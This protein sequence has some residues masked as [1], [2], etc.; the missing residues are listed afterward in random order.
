[1]AGFAYHDTVNTI[2]FT[3]TLCLNISHSLQLRNL[4]LN[5]VCCCCCL[6]RSVR[7]GDRGIFRAS[8]SRV[9]TG[10][11]QQSQLCEIN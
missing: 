9:R 10:I 1:M 11:I 2:N 7:S 3:F 5:F 4:R 6:H 8:A